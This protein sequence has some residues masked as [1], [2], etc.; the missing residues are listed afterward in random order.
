MLLLKI[1]SLFCV[2]FVNSKKRRG[3]LLVG[4]LEACVDNDRVES[5]AAKVTRINISPSSRGND[6]RRVLARS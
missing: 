1:I 4:S 6:S 5:V 3:S 2:K